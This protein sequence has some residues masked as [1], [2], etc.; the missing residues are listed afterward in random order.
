MTDQDLDIKIEKAYKRVCES[1]DD[2]IFLLV[3]L[4][5]KIRQ[6]QEYNLCSIDTTEREIV[7][8]RSSILADKIILKY[9]NQT[10]DAL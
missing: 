8:S 4:P 6:I 5:K 10:K 9:I 2:N 7:I 3:D 1:I